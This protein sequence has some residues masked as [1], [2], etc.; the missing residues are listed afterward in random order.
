MRIPVASLARLGVDSG[1]T[2]T[3]RTND[4]LIAWDAVMR[5]MS[6][7]YTLAFKDD[8]RHDG[9]RRSVDVKVRRKG[10]KAVHAAAYTLRSDDDRRAS[11][12]DA[13][14]SAPTFF[15]S[16]S[17][18]ASLRTVRPRSSSKWIGRLEVTFPL[19]PRPAAGPRPGAEAKLEVVLSRG[20]TIVHDLE[21]SFGPP[22]ERKP[23]APAVPIAVTE[24]IDVKP[25]SYTLSAV[26]FDPAV[27]MPQTVQVEVEVPA[28]PER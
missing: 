17:V 25:G 8:G 7:T 19:A 21:R 4:S 28:L 6:C 18:R 24:D 11:L 22:G 1:G 15:E 16:G 23:G 20:T 3:E 2:L 13:A 14:Y 26:L 5:R 10:L 12:M 27:Q 9:R